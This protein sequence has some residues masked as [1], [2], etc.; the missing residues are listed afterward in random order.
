MT[1]T[2]EQVN[3]LYEI[4]EYMN[5]PELTQALEFIAKVI[6]KPDVPPQVAIPELVRL[7]AIQMKLSLRATW[8]ANVD[9]SDRAKKNLY[10]TAAE[11]L[12][13]FCQTLKYVVK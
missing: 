12:Q 4:A 5:D 9:K 1:T 7:Q 2:L 8:L 13:Q 10:Y 11:S 3:D 6:F